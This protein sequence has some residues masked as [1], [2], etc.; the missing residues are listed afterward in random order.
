MMSADS[1]FSEV[2]S[3][4]AISKSSEVSSGATQ[5]ILLFKKSGDVAEY[6]EDEVLIK[7]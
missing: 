4:S 5:R 7:V 6:A 3:S 2:T 1:S